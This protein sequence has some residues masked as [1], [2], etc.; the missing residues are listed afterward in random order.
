M[1]KF[2]IPSLVVLLILVSFSNYAIAPETCTDSDGGENY[3][4]KGT[5]QYSWQNESGEMIDKCI[6][7][8]DYP[9]NYTEVESCDGPDCFLNEVECI[10]GNPTAHNYHCPNGCEE[11]ACIG[12]SHIEVLAK[13]D[14]TMWEGPVIFDLSQRSDFDGL[15]ATGLFQVPVEFTETYPEG[16]NVYIRYREEEGRF[17]VRS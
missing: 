13:L 15:D 10:D 2:L 6:L 14:G 4:V 16:M 12:Y 9:E 5:A 17:P 3:Y 11:G 8:P 1:R 7:V